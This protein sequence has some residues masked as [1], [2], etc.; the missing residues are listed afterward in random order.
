MEKQSDAVES[1]EIYKWI[2]SQDMGNLRLCY[3]GIRH[4]T[5]NPFHR[6]GVI[7]Q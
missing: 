6:Q 4:V 3:V 7:L 5:D 1:L 2:M